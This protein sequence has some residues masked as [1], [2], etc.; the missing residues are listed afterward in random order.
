MMRILQG[1][2]LLLCLALFT[3]STSAECAWVLWLSSQD[4][5]T[6]YDN[7]RTTR[8][9]HTAE[10]TF[11]SKLDCEQAI[12]RR[13]QRLAEPLR[14]GYDTVSVLADT[15]G[16]GVSVLAKGLANSSAGSPAKEDRLAMH[17]SCW[18]LGLRPKSVLGGGADYPDAVDPRGPKER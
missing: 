13:V 4:D 3:T 12:P 6:S 9:E 10:L 16:S 8:T 5:Q 2:L 11:E 18:P 1:L 7:K 14:S 15:R 17:V